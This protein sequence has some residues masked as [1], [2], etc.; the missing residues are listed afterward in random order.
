MGSIWDPRQLGNRS[1]SEA[2]A[3]FPSNG[4]ALQVSPGLVKTAMTYWV[5]KQPDWD[6]QLKYYGGIPRLAGK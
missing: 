4:D 3:E 1:T 6:Q 5:E 2:K